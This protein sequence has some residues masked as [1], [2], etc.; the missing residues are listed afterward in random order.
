MKSKLVPKHYLQIFTKFSL[1]I[2]IFAVLTVLAM[3]AYG[4]RTMGRIGMATSSS[5]PTKSALL[6]GSADLDQCANGTSDATHVPCAGNGTG[7]DGWVNGNVNPSKAHWAETEVLSYRMRFGGLTTGVSHT[8][9]IGYDTLKSGLHS[10]DYL[11]SYD[12]T[13][14]SLLGN[15]PCDTVPGCSLASFTKFDIPADPNIVDPDVIAGRLVFNSFPFDGNKMT[16]FGGTITNVSVPFAGSSSDEMRVTVTFTP[17][18]ANPV[19]AWGA[20]IAWQGEWG[21][22]LSAGAISG[23]PYHMRLIDLDGAGGNQDRALSAAAVLIPAKFTLVKLVPFALASTPTVSF[24][25]TP[26]LLDFTGATF[27]AT[28]TC[29]NVCLSPTIGISGTTSSA[30][31]T[32]P[33]LTNSLSG[34]APD[35]R[36]VQ[37]SLTPP[38]GWKVTAVGCFNSRTSD[39][40]NT[41]IAGT[42]IASGIAIATITPTE[43]DDIQCT[44]TN[45]IVTAALASITGRVTTASGYGISGAV[46]TANDVN[47][48]ATVRVLTNPFGY[49]TI[50]N[51]PVNDF[52]MVSVSSKRYSFSANSTSLVLNGDVAGLNFVADP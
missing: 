32:F 33:A 10:L 30:S 37:E 29:P 21:L 28:A 9:T 14:T 35:A 49:Y 48:S 20:H 22:G 42:N 2:A 34:L 43:G 5:N 41:S 38:H 39:T 44:F 16:L 40:T 46:V 36:T 23:S 11:S 4:Q 7:S 18:V 45:S 13:E 19:L 52:Y 50:T 8:V 25:F 47:T 51:L 15:N 31:F 1:T 12:N 6:A 26:N 24:S 17:D 3:S 27:N